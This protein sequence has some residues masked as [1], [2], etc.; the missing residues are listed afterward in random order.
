MAF[1][2]R[3]DKNS[4]P[5][6]LGE[7]QSGFTPDSIKWRSG[8]TIIEMVIV[9]SATI[10]LLLGF[11][12]LYDW[13]TKTY[14]YQEAVVRTSS[15]AR[16][17][18]QTLYTYTSQAYRVLSSGVINGTTYTSATTTM[19]LEIPSI[20]SSGNTINAKWDYLAFYVSGGNLYSN[21]Q[22]DAVSK[23]PSGKKI[24]SDTLQS[25]SFIYNNTDFNSVTEVSV[26]LMTQVPIRS[27]MVNSHMQQNLYLINYY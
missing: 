6:S 23:R 20:D 14:V 13:H 1:K 12:L 11:F 17:T 4:E 27:Q 2:E 22:P 16:G 25:I 18:M 3:T 24:L 9:I 5:E 7:F 26:D 15:D 8:F 19:V 21:A 10:V